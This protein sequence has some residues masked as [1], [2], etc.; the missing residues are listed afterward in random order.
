MILVELCLLRK[1]STCKKVKGDPYCTHFTKMN[2]R[3]HI[4]LD[5][6]VVFKKKV[7]RSF[8]NIGFENDFF[9]YDTKIMIEEKNQ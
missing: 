6:I 4:R 7:E 8:L 3:L 2:Q 5:S 9:E 1:L